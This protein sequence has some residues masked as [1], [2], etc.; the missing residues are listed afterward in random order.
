MRYGL[1]DI[2]V[3]PAGCIIEEQTDPD[4]ITLRWPLPSPGPLRYFIAVLTAGWLCCWLYLGVGA[5]WL[6]VNGGQQVPV[7]FTL[8]WVAV[9]AGGNAFGLWHLW[10]TLRP[11]R[12]ET[13]HLGLDEMR[14]DPG[15]APLNPFRSYLVHTVDF[16]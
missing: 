14:Y 11:G 10:A 13:L 2:P 16:R 15:L 1:D 3:K 4:G 9:C 6:L 5:L 7:F 12:P 8:G